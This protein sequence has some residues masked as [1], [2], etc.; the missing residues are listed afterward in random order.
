MADT[1][2]SAFAQ[3]MAVVFRGDEPP[4]AFARALFA[5]IY[6]PNKEEDPVDE[7]LPRTYRSYFYGERNITDLAKSIA[8]SLD[9]ENF[10]EEFTSANEATRLYLCEAF[11]DVCP[12]I[13]ISNYPCQIAN[14]FRKIINTLRLLKREK[15]VQ[16]Q[17]LLSVKPPR[18]IDTVCFLLPRREVFVR[19]MA[20]LSLCIKS[21]MVVLSSYMTLQLSIQRCQTTTQRI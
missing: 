17:M 9:P 10:A 18:R 8:D 7:T 11:D 16:T 13:N 4:E 1:E 12:D 15:D 20:A 21:I 2:F 19:M 14:R 6:L 3:K 5:A